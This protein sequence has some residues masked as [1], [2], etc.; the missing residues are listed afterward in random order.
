MK[1]FNKYKC[2][3]VFLI[4][5]LPS[6][7]LYYDKNRI[8]FAEKPSQ[9]EELKNKTQ[10]NKAW[11]LPE[12]NIYNVNFTLKDFDFEVQNISLHH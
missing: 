9:E 4:E 2:E 10:A 3:S 8:I 11:A 7:E 1:D 6:P 12:G 5:K